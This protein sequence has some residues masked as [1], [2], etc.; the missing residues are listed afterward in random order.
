MIYLIRL[1]Q[2]LDF[3]DR[4]EGDLIFDVELVLVRNDENDQGF[5]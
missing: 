5:F 4:R 1:G 3:V 2:I